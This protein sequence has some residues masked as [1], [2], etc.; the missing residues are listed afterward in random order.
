MNFE[1]AINTYC[2]TFATPI[3]LLRPLYYGPIN[4]N[5]SFHPSKSKKDHLFM[6]SIFP[7]VLFLACFPSLYSFTFCFEPTEK[8]GL[9]LKHYLCNP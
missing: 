8:M 6:L 5:Q 1:V 7:E 3:S 4:G 2:D 9:A